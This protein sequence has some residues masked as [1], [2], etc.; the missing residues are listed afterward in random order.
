MITGQ[1]QLKKIPIKA[2]QWS[3]YLLIILAILLCWADES[4]QFIYFQF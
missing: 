4:T 1:S 2:I 3:V